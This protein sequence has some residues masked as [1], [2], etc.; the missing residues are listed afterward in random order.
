MVS[1]SD[2]DLA[3]DFIYEIVQDLLKYNL[4]FLTFNE[5]ILLRASFAYK[6]ENRKSA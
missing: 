6:R 2:I 5:T 3:S 4:K 1:S